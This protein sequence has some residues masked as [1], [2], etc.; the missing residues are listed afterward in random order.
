MDMDIEM[1]ID[2]FKDALD[3]LDADPKLINQVP[4]P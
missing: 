4:G 2:L 1:Q 3:G